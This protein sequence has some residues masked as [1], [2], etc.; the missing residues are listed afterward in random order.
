MLTEIESN[1]LRFG[2]SELATPEIEL[3]FAL[4]Y[5]FRYV[6]HFVVDAEETQIVSVG[7]AARKPGYWLR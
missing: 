3:R 6:I 2:K 4:I 1:P 5:R 7:H